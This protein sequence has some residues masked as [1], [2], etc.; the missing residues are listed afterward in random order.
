MNILQNEHKCFKVIENQATPLTFSNFDIAG[1]DTNREYL[2]YRIIKGLEK[3]QGQLEHASRPGVPIETFTQNDLNRGLI[4][5][6]SPREIG[7]SPVEFS[8]TFIGYL[9]F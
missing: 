7:V 9:H 3:N 2:I 4:I 5:Y 1:I 6:H 8:F